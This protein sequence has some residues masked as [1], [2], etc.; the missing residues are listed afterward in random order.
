MKVA[1][2]CL[3]NWFVDGVGYQENELVRQH[4]ADGHNVLVVASTETHSEKG[5][6][7]YVQPVDYV[8]QEGA[9]IVRIPYRKILPEK[10]LRKIRSYRGLSTILE[11]FSPEYI[12]FHGTC[13]WEL[14]TVFFYMKKHPETILYVDSHEDHYNSA[15]T[16][17]SREILHKLF[18]ANVLRFVLSKVKKILCYSPES[19]EFVHSTYKVSRENLELYPLGGHPVSDNEYFTRRSKTRDLYNLSE[20]HILLVQSGKQTLRKK[21]LECIS[22]FSSIE[23][24][25]F[26]FCIAGTIDEG[27]KE[28]FLRLISKDDRIEFIGWQNIDELTDLLCAADIYVQPGTGIQSVTMQHSMCCHCAVILDDIPS[29]RYYVNNNGWLIGRDGDLSGIFQ[30]VLCADLKKMQ[31]DSHWFAKEHLDYKVLAQRIFAP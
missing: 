20:H 5:K 30:K 31:Q 1:H 9:R 17:I 4:V 16:W 7:T 26:K 19:I 2:L 8:G 27:I 3:S 18:Y 23:N 11:E 24:S 15:R 22:A 13:A 29:H 10:I 21:V 14:L 25:S 6:L 12:L 28:E